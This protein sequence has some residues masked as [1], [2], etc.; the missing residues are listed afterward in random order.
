MQR[1]VSILATT[2][3]AAKAW[4]SQKSDDHPFNGEQEDAQIIDLGYRTTHR[5]EPVTDT[6]HKYDSLTS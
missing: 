3:I 6:I 5:A 2:A 1:A 4:R